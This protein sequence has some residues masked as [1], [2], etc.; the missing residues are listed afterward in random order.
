MQ[1]SKDG[2]APHRTGIRR[3]I[4]PWEYNH[5]RFWAYVRIVA[6]ILLVLLGVILLCFG[7]WWGVLPLLAS[8]GNF[9]MGYWLLTIARSASA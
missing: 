6:G 1:P 5:L 3:L 4:A 7:I 8:A 9:L 2:V